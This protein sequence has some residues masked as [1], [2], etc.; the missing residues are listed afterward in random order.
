[1]SDVFISY[2]KA[3]RRQAEAL[4]EDL[5]LHGYS[6][7]W[8][9]ELYGG[10]DFHDVI[11]RALDGTKAV[12]VI[13]SEASVKSQWVRGE[14]QHA[15]SQHKLIPTRF[16]RLR[17]TDIPLNFRALHTELLD[18]RDRILR[19]LERLAGKRKRASTAE[20]PASEPAIT[21]RATARTENRAP[22]PAQGMARWARRQL[23]VFWVA[24]ITM[25]V[26]MYIWGRFAPAA[27]SDA[28]VFLVIG[29]GVLFILIVVQKLTHRR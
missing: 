5:K 12:I 26:L 15:Q 16:A 29:L 9:T 25:G 19:A 21:P 27:T 1:M 17:D 14:A 13:W 22:P 24:T 23:V 18:E 4:A 11:L 20:D 3:D 6:V 2:S 8:D 10:E 28:L 7:W